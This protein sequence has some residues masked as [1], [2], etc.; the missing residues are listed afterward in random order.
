MCVCV[1]VCVCVC[2]CMYVCVYV[3]VCVCVAFPYYELACRIE[4]CLW[5]VVLLFPAKPI[6]CK[7]GYCFG[8]LRYCSTVV[9]L[10]FAGDTFLMNLF[11]TMH[12]TY[13]AIFINPVYSNIGYNSNLTSLPATVFSGLASLTSMCVAA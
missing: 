9:T 12:S 11:P 6:I 7:L 13:C 5:T 8:V 4:R 3:C 1:C 2:A 10:M